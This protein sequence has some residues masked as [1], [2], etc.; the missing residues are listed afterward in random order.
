[1]FG[2]FTIAIAIEDDEDDRLGMMFGSH[3][4]YWELRVC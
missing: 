1:V 2:F 3:R 4:G